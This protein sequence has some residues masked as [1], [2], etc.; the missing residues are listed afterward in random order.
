MPCCGDWAH[1]DIRAVD[2]GIL[3]AI[4]A[5]M[6]A[7]VFSL[8]NPSA[9]LN[10]ALFSTLAD[11]LMEG[12][13]RNWNRRDSDPPWDAPDHAAQAFYQANVFAFSAAKTKAQIYDVID[14]L[15]NAKGNTR[16]FEQFEEA[17]KSKGIFNKHNRN[18]LRAEYNHAVA[19]GQAASQWLDIEDNARALAESGDVLYLRYATAGDSR[20]RPEHAR[21][22][23]IT[24]PYDDNFWNTFTPPNGWS[25][26]CTVNEVLDPPNPSDP[27]KLKISQLK[28]D[29]KTSPYFAKNWGKQPPFDM[30]KGYAKTFN[31]ESLQAERDY[32]MKSWDKIYSR[33]ANLARYKP[34]IQ[35]KEDYD[36]WWNEMASGEQATGKGG[37][38]L[39]SKLGKVVCGETLKTHPFD[40]KR[41]QVEERWK[42]YKEVTDVLSD[43]DEVWH[44]HE[45]KKGGMFYIRY[46]ED[47]PIIVRV[48]EQK[49][50]TLE[51]TTLFR[52]EPK[53]KTKD[54]KTRQNQK[55]E[56]LKQNRTGTLMYRKTS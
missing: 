30:N 35:N 5:D 45:Q 9:Y 36:A 10:M 26:R 8:D 22:E 2:E 1:T 3:S 31:P 48:N 29:T 53:P 28:R 25:C 56:R 50:K 19:A 33:P 13:N 43:P 4:W 34:Q 47:Y 23:G 7:E 17:V 15:T 44:R 14:E 38:W 32:G 16:S 11:Q 52:A 54:E 12:F 18:W 21:L 41:R 42:Y 27:A 40:S 24:L 20:V 6:L 39:D 37:F 49:D 46:Y 55:E 51:A